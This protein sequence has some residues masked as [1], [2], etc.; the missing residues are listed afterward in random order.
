MKNFFYELLYAILIVI[1]IV[2]ICYSCSDTGLRKD[3]ND[4]K[5][6]IGTECILNNDTLKVIN[7][8]MWNRDLTLSNN[9]KVNYEYYLKNKI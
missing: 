8:N 2:F 1:A 5:S 6:T 4:L 3:Y 7:F 9:V